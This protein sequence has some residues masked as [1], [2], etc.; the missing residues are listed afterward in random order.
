MR[1]R[2]ELGSFGGIALDPALYCPP[3][4]INLAQEAVQ[5]VEIWPG[6]RVPTRGKRIRIV[7]DVLVLETGAVADVVL[8]RGSGIPEVDDGVR[9]RLLRI[10]FLP[11]LL[12]GI[13]VAGQN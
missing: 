1:L 7:A 12:E 10:P 11:A 8:V 3:R 13:P 2:V 4:P 5:R 6:D 9:Q